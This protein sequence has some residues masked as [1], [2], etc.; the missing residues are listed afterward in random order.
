MLRKG[1]WLAAK[2]SVI[3]AMIVLRNWPNIVFFFQAEDGIRDPLVTGV[4]TC[5]LPIWDRRS[6]R[7]ARGFR[8][9]RLPGPVLAG[10]GGAFH[11]RCA[12]LEDLESRGSTG[13][14]A[15]RSL[16]RDQIGRASC[17]EG[18]EMSLFVVSSVIR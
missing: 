2:A 6:G 10:G 3:L 17:R 9:G 13:A 18:I 11:E 4:Q 16:R 5:A 7:L 14:I 8:R 12:V 1:T 15:G